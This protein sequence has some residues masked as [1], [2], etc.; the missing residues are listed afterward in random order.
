MLP[1]TACHVLSTAAGLYST[2]W[3]CP[4]PTA[5]RKPWRWDAKGNDV[6]GSATGTWANKPT[7]LPRPASIGAGDINCRYDARTYDEVGPDTCARLAERYGIALDKFYVLNPQ[8]AP[9]CRGIAP[10]TEYCVRGCKFTPSP[11]LAQSRYW[12]G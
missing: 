2:E 1:S 9:D 5:R 4:T 10:N 12:R 7:R 3:T 11:C 6:P 8:L